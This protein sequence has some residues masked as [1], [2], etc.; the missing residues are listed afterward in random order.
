[1]P[2]GSGLNRR[3]IFFLCFAFALI[4]LFYIAPLHPSTAVH[5]TLRTAGS[6]DAA[7]YAT[8][9]D[10]TLKGHTIM[11][12]LGNETAKCVPFQTLEPEH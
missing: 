12:K 9:Q 4:C 10:A 5:N 6:G 2:S 1:M 7:R 3:L 8:V 11:P